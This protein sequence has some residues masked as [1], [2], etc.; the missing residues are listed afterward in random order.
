MIYTK[1]VIDMVTGKTLVQE[2]YRYDGESRSAR[3]AGGA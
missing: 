3:A 1:V 2:G